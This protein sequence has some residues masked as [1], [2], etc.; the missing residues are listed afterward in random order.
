MLFKA[1]D[2]ATINTIT[3]HTAEALFCP[4]VAFDKIELVAKHNPEWWELNII[5]VENVW[6]LSCWAANIEIA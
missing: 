5:I 2:H 6:N 1:Q 3:S 4:L